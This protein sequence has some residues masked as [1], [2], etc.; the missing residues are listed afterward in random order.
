MRRPIKDKR[1]IQPDRVYDSV[2]LEQFINYIMLDGKKST[3]RKVVYDA[4]DMIKEV[5]KVKDPMEVFNGA[6]KNAGPIMEVKSRRIGG[7]NYQVPIQVK[8][9]RK[10]ALAMRWLIEA[11]R[12]KKGTSMSKRIADELMAANNKEGEV[13][14]KRENVHRMAEANKAFAHFA[15]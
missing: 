11:A 3:A 10:L 5:A 9:N 14:K 1:N 2:V 7:A 8:E 4:M 13:I 6:M 15:W 12:S